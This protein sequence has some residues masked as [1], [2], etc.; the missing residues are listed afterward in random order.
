MIKILFVCHGNICTTWETD[1]SP[2]HSLITRSSSWIWM[3]RGRQKDLETFP[4]G[5]LTAPKKCP[6]INAGFGL[7]NLTITH[8]CLECYLFLRT[9]DC[10][11]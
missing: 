10:P 3:D 2:S 6:W 1:S 7:G 4:A 5:T 11:V 9:F 8:I